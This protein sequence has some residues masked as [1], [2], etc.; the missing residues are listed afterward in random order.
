M[1]TIR[2]VFDV[3]ALDYPAIDGEQSGAD[4]EF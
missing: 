2:R 1:L 3:C 4:A